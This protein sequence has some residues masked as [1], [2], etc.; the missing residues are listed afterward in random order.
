MTPCTPL[1]D[2]FC[3]SGKKEV[4]CSANPQNRMLKVEIEI[5][6]YKYGEIAGPHVRGVVNLFSA[7]CSWIPGKPPEG[8]LVISGGKQN[9]PYL[10]SFTTIFLWNSIL[11][12]LLH[13]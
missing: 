1:G 13:D 4:K 10:L 7:K 3:Q 5:D 9:K 6:V 2:V 8:L 11:F 12:F